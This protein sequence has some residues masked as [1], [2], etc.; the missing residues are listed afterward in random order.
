MRLPRPPLAIAVPALGFL[1]LDALRCIADVSP[2]TG[3]RLIVVACWVVAILHERRAAL[4]LWM[5]Y[6][7]FLAMQWCT[8]ALQLGRTSPAVASVHAVLAACALANAGYLVFFHRDAGPA[9]N[10]D[11]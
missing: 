3:L 6:S 11:G 10:G 5:L 2:A 4:T 9:R 1:L 8:Q 7:L